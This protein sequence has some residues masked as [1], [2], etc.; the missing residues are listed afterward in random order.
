MFQVL[1]LSSKIWENK[2]RKIKKITVSMKNM[3]RLLDDKK[4][5]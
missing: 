4:K 2:Y 1:I 3:G 5:V